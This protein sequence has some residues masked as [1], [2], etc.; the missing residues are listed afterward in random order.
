MG[1]LPRLR[2][3]RQSALLS[4]LSIVAALFLSGCIFGGESDRDLSQYFPPP[5]QEGEQAVEQGATATGTAAGDAPAD[6]GA[7]YIPPAEEL[8]DLEVAPPSARFAVQSFFHLVATG[9]LSSAYERTSTE[10]KERISAEA[11]EQRYRDVWAEA[12]IGGFTWEVMP[13]D[14]QNA[15]SHEVVLRYQTTFFGEIEEIVQARA[16]RQP[17]WVVDWTPDLMFSGLGS[18]GFLVRALKIETPARGQ[19][20][21]S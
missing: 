13:Q 16:L 2:N 6:F 19:D 5:P 14:D 15:S 3:L 11:F 8:E 20:P 21:R 12:T 1:D 4:A 10:T 9:D 7:A 17:H 18:P